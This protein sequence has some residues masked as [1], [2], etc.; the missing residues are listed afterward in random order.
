[1]SLKGSCHC[2]ATVFEV[3]LAPVSVTRCTCSICSKKGALW[4]YYSPDEVRIAP[5]RSSATYRWQSMTVKHNFCPTCGCTTFT[6]SPD[7]ST[8]EPNFDNMRVAVNA[9][10]FDDFDLDAVETV[11]I[12]GKNLW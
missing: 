11:T 2:K 4:A 10:L 5:Q 6:E 9:R 12:D 8:G 3:T 7:W 1:M